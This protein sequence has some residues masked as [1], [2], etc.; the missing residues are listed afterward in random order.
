MARMDW[1]Q[2]RSGTKDYQVIKFDRDFEAVQTYSVGKEGENA[3]MCDCVAGSKFCR[4]KQMIPI[5]E[6][7]GKIDSGWFY[8]FDKKKWSK[9]L[10]EQEL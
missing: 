4:H 3:A 10:Q 5:F 7:A 2:V 1:Y 9:P 6:K 8:S